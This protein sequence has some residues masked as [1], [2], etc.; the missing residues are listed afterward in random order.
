M[1]GEFEPET[2]EDRYENAMIEL[3]RSKQAGLPTPKE[4][5][6][7]RPANVVNLM[8]ALRRSIEDRGGKAK[9]AKTPSK[10]ATEAAPKKR[11]KKAG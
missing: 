10:R 6:A 4:K 7:A 3:I 11:A 8:D 2:F 9:P 5:P 1:L